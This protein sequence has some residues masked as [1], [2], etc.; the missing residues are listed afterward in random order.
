VGRKDLA[1]Y[2]Y[3]SWLVQAIFTNHGFTVPEGKKDGGIAMRHSAKRV[4]DVLPETELTQDQP[5]ADDWLRLT[6]HLQTALLEG[7]VL[8]LPHLT[9]AAS[10]LAMQRYIGA[11]DQVMA[12]LTR[13]SEQGKLAEMTQVLTRRADQGLSGS[14]GSV[15]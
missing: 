7:Q 12:A 15:S 1:F 8:R 10:D 14:A 3:F 13:L 11:V 9:Q 6:D 4:N 5:A 2:G